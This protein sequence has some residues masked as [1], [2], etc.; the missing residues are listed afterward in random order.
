MNHPTR[1]SISN[2]PL[3]NCNGCLSIS[4]APLL[5]CKGCLSIS[6]AL[7]LNCKTCLFIYNI[8]LSN[9]NVRLSISNVRLFNSFFLKIVYWLVF[10]K[11]PFVF[12]CPPQSSLRLLSTRTI[13]ILSG[14]FHGQYR[15]FAFS[16]VLLFL[17]LQGSIL[18]ILLPE[19]V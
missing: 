14:L 10:N 5:N 17:V 3:L 8:R 9:S 19:P 11:I 1:L 6:N 15:L 18:P 4:N 12:I 13:H 7:L 16:V 2:A